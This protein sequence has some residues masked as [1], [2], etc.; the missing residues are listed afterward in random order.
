MLKLAC[1]GGGGAGLKI[2]D[3]HGRA[4]GLAGLGVLTVSHFPMRMDD[5]VCFVWGKSL[6]WILPLTHFV[7]KTKALELGE[8]GRQFSFLFGEESVLVLMKIRG[9]IE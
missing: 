1:G 3:F 5:P 7:I 2:W 9:F 4:S 6:D 8:R